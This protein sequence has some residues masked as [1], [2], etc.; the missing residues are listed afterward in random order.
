MK[1]RIA[2]AALALLMGGVMTSFAKGGATMPAKRKILVVYY[3]KTGNTE[4]V[5]KDVA[6][7]LNADIEK[8]TDLTDRSGVMGYLRGGRDAM[9]K[10]PTEI[11]P[12]QKNPADYD[13]TVIGTPV[14]GWNMTPA[15]RAY[16][17]KTKGQLK[18]V[19]FFTTA[20]GTKAEK[21]VPS[22]EELSG[23]K[24]Y[25]WIGFVGGD[26]KNAK[27]YDEKVNDFATALAGQGTYLP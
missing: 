20:G 14:W 19:A 11:G 21:I 6:A 2:V 8:I 1:L 27:K 18:E 16:I 7:K 5:A 24:A 12:L 25:A 22:M 26:L 10:R 17:T 3:S 4:K 13:I 9:K 15:V 23:K